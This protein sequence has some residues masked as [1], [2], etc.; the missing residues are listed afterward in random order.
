VSG[1][2][3]DRAHAQSS[4]ALVACSGQAPRTVRIE[5]RATAGKLDAIVGERTASPSGP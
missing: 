4:A 5:A 1:D 2:E 3:L